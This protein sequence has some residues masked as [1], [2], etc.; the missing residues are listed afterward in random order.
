MQGNMD[1]EYDETCPPQGR[2]PNPYDIRSIGF[3]LLQDQR[4]QSTNYM[5]IMHALTSNPAPLPPR[6][7]E[8]VKTMREF[9]VPPAIL[10]QKIELL[11]FVVPYHKRDVLCRES[12]VSEYAAAP[13]VDLDMFK[14]G[15]FSLFV[16]KS[17]NVYIPWTHERYHF[18][19]QRDEVVR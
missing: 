15:Q 6:P 7:H 18:I 12:R 5:R 16:F 1:G 3:F 8:F 4:A 10:I 14:K 2:Y 11:K 9:Q 19:Q 13:S 17:I